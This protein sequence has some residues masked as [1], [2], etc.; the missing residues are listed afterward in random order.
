M[1]NLVLMGPPGAGKGTQGFR[2][3]TAYRLQHLSTGDLFR[4]QSQL[5]DPLGTKIQQYME[6]GDLVP[7]KVAISVL[8][9]AMKRVDA[10]KSGILLDGFPR[11]IAQATLLDAL[12]S[13]QSQAPSLALL[14]EVP[15][16]EVKR[17]IRSRSIVQGRTDD[18][19][20]AKVLHR[21]RVYH[22]E[23]KA[24][25]DHY[26]SQGILH[27][28]AGVGSVETVAKRMAAAVTAFVTKKAAK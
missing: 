17:R 14:L 4:A 2:L 16:E 15:E 3:A 1:L 28:I 27:T 9:V 13:R 10:A 20:E 26:S 22:E 8:E 18:Q 5:G 24:V 23:T 11:T 7:D 21:L 19:D 12:W 6:S 25:I